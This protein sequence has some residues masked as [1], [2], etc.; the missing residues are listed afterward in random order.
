MTGAVAAVYEEVSDASTVIAV[1]STSTGEPP[2]TRATCTVTAPDEETVV[3]AACRA[4][5]TKLL[6]SDGTTQ[7][8]F[9]SPV[10]RVSPPG[11]V[12][13]I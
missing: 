3:T 13:T 8:A 11:S 2:L 9:P 6:S 1:E 5:M 10:V 7:N 4:V 12:T